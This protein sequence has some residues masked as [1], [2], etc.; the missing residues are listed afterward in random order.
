MQFDYSATSESIHPSALVVPNAT[1]VGQV[2][3]GEQSSVW[4][5]AVVRGDCEA[6]SIGPRTNIQDGVVIH[7]DPGLPCRLGEQVTVGHGAIVHGAE[8]EANSMI[9]IRAVILNGVRIGSGCLI[10]AGC[11]IPEGTVIPP[12]RVV[13]GIPGQVVRET[14]ES[15]QLR[16]NHA[17]QHYV[18]AQTAFRE[19]PFPS[20]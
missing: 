12:N 15:D 11:V 17:W 14:R 13:M 1:V 3:V 19:N 18:K 6:I 4:Y 5:Q 7:A 10:A 2:S 16:I 20:N 8:V 9:G